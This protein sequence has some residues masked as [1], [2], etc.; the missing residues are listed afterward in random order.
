MLLL[1]FFVLGMKGLC[2]NS[3]EVLTMYK[4]V[5]L[6]LDETLLDLNKA[7]NIKFKSSAA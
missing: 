3:V 6:D 7:L 1:L 2:Y 5:A 4:I